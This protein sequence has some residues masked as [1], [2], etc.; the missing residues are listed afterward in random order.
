MGSAAEPE[1]DGALE[2]GGGERM[3]REG[4][5]W[6]CPTLQEAVSQQAEKRAVGGKTQRVYR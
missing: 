2:R 5:V 1:G 3:Q 6:R 4:E